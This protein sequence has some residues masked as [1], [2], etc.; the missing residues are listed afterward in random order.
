MPLLPPRPEN[1]TVRPERVDAGRIAWVTASA[2]HFAL[3]A[4]LH[5]SADASVEYDG[6]RPLDNCARAVEQALA[7]GVEGALA[8]GD[9]AWANGEAGDYDRVAEML[10]PLSE[11]APVV[12]APGNHDRRDRL[13]RRFHPEAYSLND[14]AKLITVVDTPRARL[15]LLDSLYRT[16]VV[17]GLLGQAQR[18]WLGAT[19][20]S[21]PDR[22]TL[23][24]VHHPLGEDDGALLDAPR[25]LSIVEPRRQ[26]K[27]VFTAHDHVWRLGR[28]G[29]LHVVKLPA[30]GFPFLPTEPTG[31]VAL[32]LR[33]AS[34]RLRFHSETGV[35]EHTLEWRAPL[36]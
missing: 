3:L 26:V 33:D 29:D 19:L 14:P 12:L 7:A 22:P 21:A 15:M 25:L 32:E 31:W 2:S 24:F 13:L 1:W 4:D 20:D 8:D 30:V 10:A 34:A 16:D 35:E 23:L 6:F 17:P 5:L 11:R 28:E 27:A 9:L 36:K 18:H